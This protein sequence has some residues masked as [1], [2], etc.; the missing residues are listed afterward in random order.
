MCKRHT[1]ELSA[2]I[3]NRLLSRYPGL[4]IRESQ[5][6]N[7]VYI[8]QPLLSIV[9]SR[10]RKYRM[11]TF[12]I[13]V[14]D[15]GRMVDRNSTISIFRRNLSVRDFFTVYHRANA[16]IEELLDLNI[17]SATNCVFEEIQKK[18]LNNQKLKY[19]GLLSIVTKAKRQAQ[20]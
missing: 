1:D 3:F 17:R 10:H 6:S 14:S 5:S 20:Q 16:L 13:R 15:H 9:T 11:K 12:T 4:R 18:A 19:H 8:Y 2:Y 7:S